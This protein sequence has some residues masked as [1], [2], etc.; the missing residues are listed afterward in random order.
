MHAAYHTLLNHELDRVRPN[1]HMCVH[2]AMQKY[3]GTD[4]DKYLAPSLST[5]KVCSWMLWGGELIG[6]NDSKTFSP[7]PTSTKQ[8]NLEAG[9]NL[10][11]SGGKP[12][13][14]YG[15][16]SLPNWWGF[17]RHCQGQRIEV[18]SFFMHGFCPHRD[19]KR[20]KRESN[21]ESTAEGRD[22]RQGAGWWWERRWE[23]EGRAF[24]KARGGV[25]GWLS[26]WDS[27]AVGHIII[28][29]IFFCD[30]RGRLSLHAVVSVLCLSRRVMAEHWE[31]N[32]VAGW[33]FASLLVFKG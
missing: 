24:V 5:S 4:K 29:C 2:A 16:L 8:D 20:R 1:V 9:G 30:R 17:M 10:E 3:S 23:G 31:F 6:W 7:V 22:E 21:G 12:K 25:K 14:N 33:M 28:A 13:W 27:L 32:W 26:G 18:I 19:L 15:E 11:G